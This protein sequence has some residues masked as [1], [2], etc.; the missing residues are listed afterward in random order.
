MPL[1]QRLESRLGLTRGDVTIALFLAATACAGLVYTEFVESDR[2]FRQR[3]G[4][5]SLI[6]R[7]DSVAAA[8]EQSLAGY[9]ASDSDTVARPWQPLSEEE[10][11]EEGMRESSDGRSAELTLEDVA[12]ININSASSLLLQL[13]PGV[14]EKTAEKIIAERPFLKVEEIMRV[15]GIGEKK[16]AKMRPYITTGRLQ[17]AKSGIVPEKD[18][19]EEE[20]GIEQGEKKEQEEEQAGQEAEKEQQNP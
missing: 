13:L 4:L 19:K 3:T 15:K 1:I 7:S 5:A 14:G 6:A 9:L 20:E 8:R 11:L 12:P 2:T 10:V 16:F 18:E 17:P